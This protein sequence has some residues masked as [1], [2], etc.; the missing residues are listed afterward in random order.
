[1]SF[2]GKQVLLGVSGGIAAYKAAE[3]VRR[4]VGE[5]ARVKVVMTAAAREFVQPLTFEALS[6]QPVACRLFG[7]GTQPLEHVAL[8]QEVDA[9]IIA[10]ATANLIGKLAA[11]LG[12]D[13]LTTVMLAATRPVLLCPAMNDRM[14]DN[15]VVRENLDRLSARG[16]Q[17]LP[18]ASGDL[19]CGAVG[20]GRLPEPELIV[21]AAARLVTPQDLAGARLVVTA[22]PTHEDLD[23]VRFLTNRSTGK[24]G[25][26]VA[27]MARRRGAVVTL[28]TGPSSLAAPHGVEVVPVRSAREMLA[29]VEK[30]F[31][32]ADALIMAAAVGDY[33]PESL[34]ET[35]LKRGK[36]HLEVSLVQNPDI[37]KAVA[38]R[39]GRR[40][41][42][43]FAAE[44]GA[45]LAEAGRKLRE[46][47]LDLIVANEVNRPDAGFAADTNEVVL[48]SRQEP[49]VALPLMSKEEVADRILDWLA[50]RLAARRQEEPGG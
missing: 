12:D 32:A 26:A 4:L 33:R 42:V 44:T 18:P 13:L 50:P 28:V 11:G 24:M 21:E 48:L 25:Y 7:P 40:L 43:G 45:L 15:P 35:K 36:D 8:G 46:K 9:V 30:H 22:G 37:L 47:N 31:D 6:G 19:A 20:P 38:A 16:Y 5:G 2:A 10:P 17:V 27:K 41:V 1:M 34:A 29:A 23:P 3:V 49:P 14:W 39:K